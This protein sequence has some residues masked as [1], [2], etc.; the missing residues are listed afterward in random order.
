MSEAAVWA[1][2]GALTFETAVSSL[3]QA[4]AA[5]PACVDLTGVS[6]ADSAALAL[7]VALAREQ[8]GHDRRLSIRAMPEGMAALADLYGVADLFDISASDE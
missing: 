2:Q 1:P 3:G 7:L 6:E 5:R 8:A 4:R